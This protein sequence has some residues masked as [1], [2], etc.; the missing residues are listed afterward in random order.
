[1][2]DTLQIDNLLDAGKRIISHDLQENH[3]H[4]KWECWDRVKD[5]FANVYNNQR[6]P[7]YPIEQGTRLRAAEGL[8]KPGKIDR[9]RL[10]RIDQ[11]T[12]SRF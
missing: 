2:R 5:A 11:M 4:G 7:T 1:L 6:R 10:N 12:L 3:C 9:T 8:N